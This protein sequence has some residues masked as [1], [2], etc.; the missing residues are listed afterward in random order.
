M[1]PTGQGM[2]YNADI[3]AAATHLSPHQTSS[4]YSDTVSR[5]SVYTGSE[6]S[7][8]VQGAAVSATGQQTATETTRDTGKRRPLQPSSAPLVYQHEDAGNDVV[9]LPPAY[10]EWSGAPPGAPS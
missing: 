3:V 6:R 1:T 8:P 7:G 9:E 4:V 5:H 2:S 10:R